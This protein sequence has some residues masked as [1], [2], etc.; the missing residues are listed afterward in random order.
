MES[1][2]GRIGNR[3]RRIGIGEITGIRHHVTSH[4]PIGSIDRSVL[5]TNGTKYVVRRVC[6][7]G[8]LYWGGCMRCDAIWI[9]IYAHLYINDI[10]H[11]LIR[12]HYHCCSSS[13]ISLSLSL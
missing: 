10:H 7:W 2:N 5:F 9:C 1:R 12:C 13:P 8:G 6:V 11:S 4:V 3:A